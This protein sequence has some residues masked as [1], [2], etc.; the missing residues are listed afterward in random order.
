MPLSTNAG[1]SMSN[2]GE[3]LFTWNDRLPGD[4]MSV[5]IEDD[6]LRD[7]LQASFIRK[8]TV[9]EKAELVRLSAGIGSRHAVL[10]FPASSPAEFSDSQRLLSVISDDGLPLM[11]WFL[12]RAMR[13]DLEPMLRLRDHFGADVG[14]AFFIGTSPIR[15]HVEEWDMAQILDRITGTMEYLEKVGLPFSFSVEDASRTPP[16]ELRTMVELAVQHSAYSIAVCDTVGESTPAGV[17]RL[18]GF[19]KKIIRDRGSDLK[20]LWHGHNDRGLGLANSLAAVE[21]GADIVGGA[22]LGIGERS[23]NTALEQVIMYLHQNG[24]GNFEVKGLIPYLKKL[25]AATDFPIPVNMPLVGQQAFATCT[26]THAAAVLK[27]AEL[28]TDFEDYVFSSIPASELGAVQDIGVGPTSGMANAKYVLEKG[29]M[30]A[31]EG[32]AAELL[33]FAKKQQ[34]LMYEDE[35]TAWYKQRVVKGS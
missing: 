27:A 28:G 15:R 31:S 12:G 20:I 4:R 21:A 19:V 7:G 17:H 8:P 2:I 24:I 23:G 22:F 29:A 11:P 30:D 26:G 9:E 10:G 33:A 35:I 13:E 16:D 14:A 1:V 25:S 3:I 18:V 34:R 6:T 5:E 32:T